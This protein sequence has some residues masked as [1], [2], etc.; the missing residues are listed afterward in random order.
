MA[1]RKRKNRLNWKNLLVLA[2]SS[3]L[4]LSIGEWVYRKMLFGDQP[5]FEKIR[6]PG[7]YAHEGSQEYW[8]L[9]HI[10]QKGA[11]APQH[12][13]PWLGWTGAFSK[14]SYLHDSFPMSRG[15]RPVL[16]YGDSFAQCM[17]EVECFEDILNADTSFTRSHYLLNY[18]VGGYGVDQMQLLMHQTAHRY[19]KPFVIFSLLTQDLDRSGLPLRTGLKPYY[20]L[21]HDSLLLQGVPIT[22]TADS[23]VATHS[24][25]IFSYLS[26]RLAWSGKLDW[27][28]TP[29]LGRMKGSNALFDQKRALNAAILDKVLAELKS[30]DCD[31]LFLVFQNN[32]FAGF[33]DPSDDWREVFL[34]D[35]FTRNQVPFL[36]TS[37]LVAAD[38]ASSGKD[39]GEYMIPGNGHPTTLCNR[40]IA[41]GMKAEVLKKQLP[42]ID[43][44]SE[45]GEY[46]WEI[47]NW[48]NKIRED[49]A[50]MKKL[51]TEAE[52]KQL[53]LE[54]LISRNAIYMMDKG[55]AE[56]RKAS[57]ESA[58][59]LIINLP[60]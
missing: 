26:R 22:L 46:A 19:H 3:V 16:L 17:E 4:A 32:G 25:G 2:I 23:F 33:E 47:L 1:E 24:P 55:A 54:T 60:Q 37:E 59:S 45:P 12:P 42:S 48:E 56:F 35:W 28:P 40:I 31:F 15:R 10:F 43:T 50:W 58:D 27:L 38:A 11:G 34:R 49:S 44:V 29:V 36:F 5:A 13:H 51:G 30:M 21:D 18:G 20:I 53:L 6:Q 39:Y 57:P 41:G 52:E 7:L 9:H 14:T 8:I